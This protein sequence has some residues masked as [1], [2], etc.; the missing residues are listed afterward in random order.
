MSEGHAPP[1]PE[2]INTPRGAAV[3]NPRITIHLQ[4][5]SVTSPWG[6]PETPR[7]LAVPGLNRW[8]GERIG[9]PQSVRFTVT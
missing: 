7:S 9:P 1:E 8:L 5:G 3:V 6:G 4:T 2:I